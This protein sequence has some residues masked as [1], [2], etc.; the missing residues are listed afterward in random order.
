[1]VRVVVRVR[2][3][4]PLRAG[5]GQVGKGSSKGKGQGTPAGCV[6]ACCLPAW[7]SPPALP[8]GRALTRTDNTGCSVAPPALSATLVPP[9]VLTVD[10]GKKGGGCT[11]M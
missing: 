9:Q 3:R 11:I 8:L 5:Q 6:D 10:K 7:P 4:V 1:M 2:G